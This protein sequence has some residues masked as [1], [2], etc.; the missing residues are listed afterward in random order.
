VPPDLLRDPTLRRPA[1]LLAVLIATV[2]IGERALTIALDGV[3]EG[4]ATVPAWLPRLG[5]IGETVVFY[6]AL[7]DALKFLA[8]PAA[9]VWLAYAYGRRRGGG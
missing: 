5:T 1:A 8:V 6:A 4:A 9:L 2:A 7:F 3:G